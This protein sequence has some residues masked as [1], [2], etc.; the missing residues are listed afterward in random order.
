MYT[1]IVKSI[2]T[3]AWLAISFVG[4]EPEANFLDLAT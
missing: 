2:W 1:E 4:L 3:P